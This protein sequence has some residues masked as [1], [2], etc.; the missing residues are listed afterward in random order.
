LV[1]PIT[2]GRDP[3]YPESSTLTERPKLLLPGDVIN[4][5]LPDVQYD[6]INVIL[7]NLKYNGSIKRMRIRVGQ[8]IFNDGTSWDTGTMFR[9]DPNDPGLWHRIEDL[10]AA[11]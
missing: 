2:Y 1:A 11:L 5:S 4:I 8:V 9:R 7:K 10:E 3:A 6:N